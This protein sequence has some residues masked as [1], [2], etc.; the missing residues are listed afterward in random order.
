MSIPVLNGLPPIPGFDRPWSPTRPLV[1]EDHLTVARKLE[2]LSA[3]L[4]TNLIDHLNKEVAEIIEAIDKYRELIEASMGELDE[5]VRERLAENEER[6]NAAVL[7]VINSSIEL[8]DPVM[9]GIVS[10]LTSATSEQLNLLFSR[11]FSIDVRDY[12]WV[13]SV[14]VDNT[15][16]IQ[17]A[18]NAGGIGGCV[19]L[20]PGIFTVNGTV[21]ML[22]GSH[23]VAAG[24]RTTTLRSEAD[25]TMF[26]SVGGQAQGLHGFTIQH[27][28]AGVRT[29]YDISFINPTRP[30][31]SDIEVICSSTSSG[32][33]GISF[34]KDSAQ[35]GSNAFMPV[36]DR[37][38]VRDGHLIIDGVTD[39]KVSNSYVW[40]PGRGTSTAA[41]HMTNISNSWTFTGVDV[42][43]TPGDTGNGYYIH[44]TWN[45]AI[46]G[47]YI[48]GSYPD[49]MTGYGITVVD[50]GQLIVSGYNVYNVGRSA[51]RLVNTVGCVVGNTV[52]SGANKTGLGYPDI[53]LVNS[54]NNTFLNTN[55]KQA[56]D[57]AVKG[58]IFR[59]DVASSHNKID[60]T[61][62]DISQGNFYAPQLIA[63]NA[64]TQGKNCRPTALFPRPAGVGYALPV[65]RGA[66]AQGP[67]PGAGRIILSRFTVPDGAVYRYAAIRVE[68]GVGNM[69]ACIYSVDGSGNLK[70]V[71][72]SAGM[73]VNGATNVIFDLSSLYYA[74]GDYAFAVWAD[75][76]TIQTFMNSG[77]NLA[78]SRLCGDLTNAGGLPETTAVASWNGT[79]ELAPVALY[80]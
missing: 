75:S 43:P 33:G 25:V 29:T 59:E 72:S 5:S 28:Q 31:L 50:G 73:P 68:A 70:K 60:Y 12:G 57:R 11:K 52:I 24:I 6:I 66:G 71:S 27:W 13:N 18:V 80:A 1:Y 62:L 61:T 53:D 41:I 78:L 51:F 15:A 21:N 14:L 2:F 39:G 26:R 44:R 47:G 8:Q 16:A 76:T 17:R 79:R 35:A 34:R 55:H 30:T 69:A 20:P 58:A 65:T 54:R 48:D 77:N 64:G 63:A 46:V 32:A 23:V 19:R 4:Q 49:N 3:W 7:Q 10:D 38:W 9:A 40:G 67:W 45:T 42:I 74:P 56:T 36:L 22:D 37:V